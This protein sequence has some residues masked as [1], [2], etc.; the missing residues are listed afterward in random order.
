MIACPRCGWIADV[1]QAREDAAWAEHA[2][3][4]LCADVEPVRGKT[5]S[6]RA[7]LCIHGHRR[8][9]F[10]ICWTCVA[11]K[12][13]HVLRARTRSRSRRR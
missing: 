8:D 5:S 13:A 1:P 11:S 4:P 6:H 10:G 7:P 2:R 3:D 12:P 9:A